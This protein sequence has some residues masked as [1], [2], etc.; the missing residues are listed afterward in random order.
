MAVAVAVALSTHTP[1]ASRPSKLSPPSP[2]SDPAYRTTL[3]DICSIPPRSRTNPQFNGDALTHSAPPREQTITYV[4]M[5]DTLDG[6]RT[7]RQQAGCRAACGAAGGG[8]P[9]LYGVY[10][11]GR[12]PARAGGVEGLECC[13]EEERGW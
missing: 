13:G 11:Y 9:E 5:G 1:T 6:R 10:G 3:L 2:S 4:W 7:A 12:V 8:V